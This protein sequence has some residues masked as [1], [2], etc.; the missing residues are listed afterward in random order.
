MLWRAGLLHGVGRRGLLERGRG[1][2]GLL[3]DQHAQRPAPARRRLGRGHV[4]QVRPGAH[5]QRLHAVA[6]AG[7][8]QRRHLGGLEPQHQAAGPHALLDVGAAAHGILPPARL[9]GHP[10][11]HRVVALE[12]L[13]KGRHPAHGK[14]QQSAGHLDVGTIVVMATLLG[15]HLARARGHSIEPAP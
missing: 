1:D 11:D 8:G 3:P 10:L 2:G 4:A 12:V 7:V 9:V 15:L 5:Q 6:A 13:G 14:V